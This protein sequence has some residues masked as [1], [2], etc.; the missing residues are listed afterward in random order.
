MFCQ[1]LFDDVHEMVN[2]A[3]NDPKNAGK[4]DN[5]IEKVVEGGLNK[6]LKE[7]CLVNQVY[8]MAA[9]GK[10]T[11]DQYVSEVAKSNNANIKIDKFIR[12][13]TGE[14]IEKRQE[15]FAAEVAKQMGN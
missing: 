13:E 10:Q 5:I 9:D 2:K 11:I 3:K 14:G 8:I 15:D 1:S 12:Y 7:V 4:P 6:E